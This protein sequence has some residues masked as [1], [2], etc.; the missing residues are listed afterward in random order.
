MLAAAAA[1]T[2]VSCGCGLGGRVFGLNELT[3]GFVFVFV[4]MNLAFDGDELCRYED[5][6]EGFADGRCCCC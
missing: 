5:M 3:Y 4:F 6:N 2:G 1:A